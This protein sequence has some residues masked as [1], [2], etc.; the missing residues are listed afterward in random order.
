MIE[1]TMLGEMAAIA[2]RHASG[3]ETPTAVPRMTIWRS[4]APTGPTPAMYAAKF[5]VL[6]QGRKV[7]T[8]GGRTLDVR[9]G[10]YSICSVPLPFMGRIVEAS[11]D[12]PYVA[13][14][15][16]LRPGLL[17]ELLLDVPGPHA[18]EVP[19][20]ASAR[21]AADV[22]EPLDRLLRLLSK[23]ADIPVLAPSYERE[24]YY[25]L[26]QGPMGDTLRQIVGH[27]TR[28]D[29]IRT[30]VEWIVG[31]ADRPMR[32]ADLAASVG[33]SATS[34]HR[35]FKGVTGHSPLA[36]QRQLRL[37]DARRLLAS[38][39]TNVTEAAFEKGYA[40]SSQFSREYKRMFGIP[41]MRDLRVLATGTADAAR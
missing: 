41:P 36:Y 19:A 1:R 17:A 23:P 12:K 34:F 40:S 5:Y 18:R 37:L 27:A 29:Q 33:M 22:L 11:P 39:A 15:F 6:L 25:R 9:A 31:H 21:A 28:F 4:D 14:S 16:A 20:V 38:G 13:L 24:L 10:D 3:L 8:I 32:V 26:L 30:A 35:H 2:A 7:K